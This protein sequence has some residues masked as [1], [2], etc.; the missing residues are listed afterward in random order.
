M[1]NGQIADIPRTNYL[2]THIAAMQRARLKGVRV[3][4]YHVWSSHDNLEWISGYGRR[5]GMIYVDFK[6][7]QRILKDSAVDYGAYVKSQLSSRK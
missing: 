1:K 2:K 6:S 3:Y 4:G 7:Q 5:F